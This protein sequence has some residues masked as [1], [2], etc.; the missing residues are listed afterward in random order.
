[1]HDMTLSSLGLINDEVTCFITLNGK[2]QVSKEELAKAIP[3]M[4]RRRL[5]G[6]GRNAVALGAH[7]LDLY[8][9]ID[10]IIFASRTGETLRCLDML[11]A[12]LKGE[13]VSP[14]DFS[15]SVHN[16]TV[17]VLA[18]AKKFKGETTAVAAGENTLQVAFEEAYAAM[19]GGSAQKVLLICFEDNLLAQNVMDFEGRQEFGTAW[20]TS[21]VL[22]KQDESTITQTE[23]RGLPCNIKLS[24]VMLEPKQTALNF[25]L[26][27]IL[28]LG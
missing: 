27:F 7:T 17:G 28:K 11:Q 13:A 10:L 18:I 20:A 22:E 9:N 25:V 1:M 5:K 14:A 12:V 2:E 3:M 6:A 19:Y 26:K 23:Q 16:A 8:D 4:L 15:G 24:D 21:L